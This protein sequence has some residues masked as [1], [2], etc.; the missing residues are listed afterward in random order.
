MNKLIISIAVFTLF[1][2]ACST[3]PHSLNAGERI[4][5]RGGSIGE[6]GDAWS[7]GQ[8]GVRDGEK[9]VG[10]SSDNL[11]EAER[12]LTRARARVARA[13]QEITEAS[14]DRIAGQRLIHDGTVQ[15]QQAEADYIAIRAGPSAVSPGN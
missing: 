10:K 14:A 5:Q 13:E 15:M 12:D 9:L 2:G 3:S 6:F 8:K 7:S 11:A 4:S 1:A